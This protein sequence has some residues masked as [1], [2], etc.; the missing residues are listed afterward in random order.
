MKR[1]MEINLLQDLLIIGIIPNDVD[2]YNGLI[3][4]LIIN[5][6]AINMLIQI[7]IF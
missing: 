4:D 6:F 1:K 5:P 3:S 7:N 2:I